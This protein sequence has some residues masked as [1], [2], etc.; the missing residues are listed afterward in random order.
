MD[1]EISNLDHN[2]KSPLS[3]FIGITVAAIAIF[4]F[5][6]F[7]M[8]TLYTLIALQCCF[9]LMMLSTIHMIQPARSIMLAG[10]GLVLLFIVFDT[11]SVWYNSIYL[12]II[13]YL[14]DF[15]FLFMAIIILFRRLVGVK[16]VNTK[17]IFAAMAIYILSGI[18]WGKIYFLIDALVPGSFHGFSNIN[19]ENDGFHNGFKDQF[20]LVYYSFS[21]ISTLGLGDI[22]P[23]HH[24]A[25]SFTVFE[26]VFGQLF[27]ATVIAKLVSVWRNPN[28]IDPSLRQL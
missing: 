14:F 8:S 3:G 13:A 10:L 2:L 16:V 25:K 19:L 18:L 15:I 22:T 26:A 21:T 27:V 23:I 11:L 17:L 28:Q 5:V 1:N 20:D 4:L 6:P 7:L 12:M 24:M 9:T